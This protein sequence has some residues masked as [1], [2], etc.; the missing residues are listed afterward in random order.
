M[1]KNLHKL[2]NI[3][4]LEFVAKKLRI[5][6][7]PN[8][9]AIINLL[10]NNTGLNVGQ[11]QKKLN[12]RKTDTSQHLMLMHSYGLLNRQRLGKSTIYS[13]NQKAIEEIIKI[14]EDLFDK[15]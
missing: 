15:K 5:I 4:N 9:L 8:R 7:H 12:F 11:I 10:N 13:V 14:S 3:K 6:A 1:E 2:I